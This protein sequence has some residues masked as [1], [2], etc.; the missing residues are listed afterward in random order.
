MGLPS[1]TVP[2]AY[3]FLIGQSSKAM[4]DNSRIPATTPKRYPD[5]D[6]MEGCDN[7][8]DSD[9]D[10]NCLKSVTQGMEQLRKS[11]QHEI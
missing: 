10:Q 4:I 3:V 9:K 5:R 6:L 7:H 8:F 2:T 1:F 11:C